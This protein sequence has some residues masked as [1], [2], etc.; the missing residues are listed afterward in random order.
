MILTQISNQKIEVRFTTIKIAYMQEQLNDYIA[1]GE[2]WESM[3]GTK[4]NII[5]KSNCGNTI[6]L[7]K[8][9]PSS[10]S[11]HYSENKNHD[12]IEKI[13]DQLSLDLIDNGITDSGFNT[14]GFYYKSHSAYYKKIQC[15]NC[16]E[17]YMI[18]FS[19]K[20]GATRP[21][22]PNINYLHGIY[23]CSTAEKESFDDYI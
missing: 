12:E 2:K 17:N 3:P 22:R 4:S 7:L 20:P 10:F 11:L 14:R 16:C 5:F 15:P 6:E 18:C 1:F 8:C 21:D 9:N 23:L 19:I 13:G